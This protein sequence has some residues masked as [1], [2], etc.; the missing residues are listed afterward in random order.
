M[1]RRLPLLVIGAALI[2]TSVGCNNYVTAGDLAS[3]YWPIGGPNASPAKQEVAAL[4]QS[5]EIHQMAATSQTQKRTRVAIS[6]TGKKALVTEH[7]VHGCLAMIEVRQ[8]V[9]PAIDILTTNMRRV[10]YGP[11][12][13][14]LYV[15]NPFQMA[16]VLR[17]I[18]TQSYDARP[19]IA[20]RAYR[21][22]DGIT[23]PVQVM[24]GEQPAWQA[25]EPID[26][27]IRTECWPASVMFMQGLRPEGRQAN[28]MLFPP[29]GRWL[30]TAN[31]QSGAHVPAFVNHDLHKVLVVIGW[32][33][34]Y[35]TNIFN[36]PHNGALAEM[37]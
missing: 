14:Q 28:G 22:C 13:R 30:L 12:T 16:D 7:R 6:A 36:T 18:R 8:A 26:L 19:E 23:H 3:W 2:A 9:D 1:F 15:I 24:Q 37:R 29:D 21:D 27:T 25:I 11:S 10:E 32:T 17:V 35:D 31:G 5:G 20:L 33:Q 4:I 34:L